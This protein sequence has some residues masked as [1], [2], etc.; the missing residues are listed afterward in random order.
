M[1]CGA[2]FIGDNIKSFPYLK[3]QNP[4]PVSGSYFLPIV[5]PITGRSSISTFPGGFMTTGSNSIWNLRGGFRRKLR[6]RFTG[7]RKC[8]GTDQERKRA[9]DKRENR[10]SGALM[11]IGRSIWQ[12]LHTCLQPASSDTRARR[13]ARP[14]AGWTY[15]PFP[16]EWRARWSS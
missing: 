3:S 8:S 5:P 15:S 1:S 2:G 11:F 9:P 16:P 13:A 14:R 4:V 7:R 10:L 12:C 6:E